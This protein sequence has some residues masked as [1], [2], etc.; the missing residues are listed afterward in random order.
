M[1]KVACDLCGHSIDTRVETY[2]REVRG[3]A[4][5]RAQGGTNALVFRR[6]LPGVR[7]NG[8]VESAKLGITASQTKLDFGSGSGN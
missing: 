8:C 6:E 3:W 2:Y 5:V 4:K 7:C 1:K